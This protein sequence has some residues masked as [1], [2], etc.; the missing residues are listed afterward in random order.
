MQQNGLKPEPLP[1]PDSPK[2]QPKPIQQQQQQQQQ[3]QPIPQQQQH[4]TKLTKFFP[5]RRSERRPKTEVEA[6]QQKTI[7]DRLAVNNDSELG[8]KIQFFPEKV[9]KEMRSLTFY[10]DLWKSNMKHWKTEYC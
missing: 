4:Q 3:Q 7:E 8:L 10:H 1:S 5:I 9:M 2:V 6:K